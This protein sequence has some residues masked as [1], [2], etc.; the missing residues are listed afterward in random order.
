MRKN[1]HLVCILGALAGAACGDSGSSNSGEEGPSNAELKQ[2]A[3]AALADPDTAVS[4]DPCEANAWYGD[5]ECDAWCPEGDADDCTT[6]SDDP[7]AC[8]LFFSEADGLCDRDDPCGPVQDADCQ[9]PDPGD[10]D[11]P[12]VCIELLF[13]TNGK[14]EPAAGCEYTDPED[15][16]D[17]DLICPAIW[18]PADGK[19][20]T[21]DPCG[22]ATDEDCANQ[23]GGSDPTDPIA[24]IE[25][26]YAANGKC[27]AAEGCEYTDPEDC[28][29]AGS[30]PG[31]EGSGLVCPA[32]YREKDGT[33]PAN[34]P[35]DPDC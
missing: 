32:I 26:A 34:D 28:T 22:P 30:S 12:V 7:V 1:W 14:C 24:C 13:P 9:S 2:Q 17:D 6:S 35:C 18:S 16:G 10:G 31:N 3:R 25:I 5:A 27:E 20:D 23:G 33:C 11:D 4:S 29:S 8:A 19:C 21:S 15:C